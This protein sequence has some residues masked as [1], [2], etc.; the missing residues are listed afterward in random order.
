[1]LNV[2]TVSMNRAGDLPLTFEKVAALSSVDLILLDSRVS[3]Q[4]APPLTRIRPRHHA[5][6]KSLARGMR[7]GIAAATHGYSVSRVSILASDP[8]FKEL[9][10]H[11]RREEDYEYADVKQRLTDLTVAAI[12]ELAERLENDPAK[13]STAVLAKVVTVAAD[14]SGFGPKTQSDVNVTFGLAERM[15]AARERI[16]RASQESDPLTIE[17][18][19]LPAAE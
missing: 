9:I 7:P 18:V 8:T 2:A 13:I 12:D 6:A 14:R 11:Y 10:E 19:A 3:V 4:S 15:R 5:L 1:M 16:A 17:G